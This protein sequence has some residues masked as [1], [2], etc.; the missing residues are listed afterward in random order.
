KTVLV[1]PAV[2]LHLS[3]SLLRADVRRRAHDHSRLSDRVSSSEAHSFGDAEIHHHCHVLVEHDV[4]GL[5][6]AVDDLP[7]MRV[8]ERARNGSPD[9]ERILERKLSLT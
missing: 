8:V 3:G 6:V 7:A 9:A 4:L 1:A 5:Y 2:D